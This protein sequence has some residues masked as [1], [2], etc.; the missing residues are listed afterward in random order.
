MSEGLGKLHFW[1]SMPVFPAFIAMHYLGLGG[2]LRRS[3]D[4]TFYSYAQS[5]QWIN[6]AI[7]IALFIAAAAQIVFFVN[8]IWSRLRGKLASENPWESA[9]LEWTT[10]SP[11]PHLNW[12]NVPEVYRGP[13]EYRV[14]NG[15]DG[16]TPQHAP[17]EH[18][19][20]LAP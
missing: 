11:A 1:L 20:E 12:E 18:V 4:P 3:Y 14:G 13:Y 8:L 10:P 5:T 6:V 9:T 16:Y 7:S 2:H 19:E 15:G 17:P